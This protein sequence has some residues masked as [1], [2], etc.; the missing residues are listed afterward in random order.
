M[1]FIFNLKIS[2]VASYYIL[3]FFPYI[4]KSSSSV[5]ISFLTS[6]KPLPTK[7]SYVITK[8]FVCPAKTLTRLIFILEPRSSLKFV[9]LSLALL[10]CAFLCW[11]QSCSKEFHL[12]FLAPRCLELAGRIP[13]FSPSYIIPLYAVFWILCS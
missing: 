7:L 6:S 1:K 5:F 13:S 12:S 3:H 9:L 10:H 8:H 11:I 4:Y 2:S